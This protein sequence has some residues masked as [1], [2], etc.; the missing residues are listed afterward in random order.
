M[1]CLCNRSSNPFWDDSISVQGR[2]EGRRNEAT[3]L[4]TGSQQKTRYKRANNQARLPHPYPFLTCLQ[5]IH[6]LLAT[7]TYISQ[8]RCPPPLVLPPKRDNPRLRR[9]CAHSRT[10]VEVGHGCLSLSPVTA[11]MV[12]IQNMPPFTKSESSGSANNWKNHPALTTGQTEAQTLKM[13]G[14]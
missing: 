10:E 11:G 13:F 12:K 1:I 9:L 3:Y 2:N 4:C 14:C 6:L 8:Q 5:T 7:T